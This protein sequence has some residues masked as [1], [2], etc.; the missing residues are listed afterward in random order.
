MKDTTL[1]NLSISAL[2]LVNTVAQDSAT[3]EWTSLLDADLTQWELWMGAPHVT[4]Q[5]LPEGTPMSKDGHGGKALGLNNDPKHVFSVKMEEDEPVLHTTGEIFGG[6]T[7][8]KSYSDY[9]FRA[10][11][12][13]GG[14]KWEPKLDALRDNGILFHCTG[15]HGAFWNVWKQS[16]EF[17]V[18]EKNMGDLYL[19]A[20]TSARLPAAQK[21]GKGKWYY[22]PAGE[23]KSFGRI[24]GAAG[25]N[26]SHL[27]GS[28]EKPN[29]EWNTLELYA[30][31]RSAVFV[32]NG[33]VVQVLHDIA[34]ADKPRE[35]PKPLSEGQIQIQSEGAECYYRR[36][37]IQP[38]TA[39]PAV[40]HTA[41]SYR[42]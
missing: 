11:F 26:T 12:K 23:M 21:D 15:R 37:E 24:T 32:V 17:Q 30:I 4:V 35:E 13:W 16:V 25:G 36:M 8:L 29:G 14:K 39:L 10:Q 31:G 22:D 9:H 20:G 19:L 33:H 38:I 1:L 18:E 5:G 3:S 34:K 27:P 41:A 42:E 6:L 7:T 2:L 28:F 40:I